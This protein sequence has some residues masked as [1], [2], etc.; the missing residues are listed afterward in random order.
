MPLRSIINNHQNFGPENLSQIES[1]SNGNCL[2][3]SIIYH[4]YNNFR[5]HIEIRNKIIKSLTIKEE[6]IPNVT[7]NDNIGNNIPIKEYAKT[8]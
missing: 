4:C 7:F 6:E 3:L 8:L 5:Y 2:Y 1:E